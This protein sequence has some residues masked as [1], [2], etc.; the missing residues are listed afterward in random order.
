MKAKN[1]MAAEINCEFCNETSLQTTL[2]WSCANSSSSSSLATGLSQNRLQIINYLSQLLLWLIPCLPLR[3]SHCVHTLQTISYF[4][5]HTDTSPPPCQNWNLWPASFLL[6][7]SKAMESSPFWYLSH[8]VLPCLQNCFKDSPRA[9]NNST[10]DFKFCLL[11]FLISPSP[12]S[13]SHPR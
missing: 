11:S 3:P 2:T 9:T 7:C 13:F 12:T 1:N 4:C 10:T 8:L 5:R 6:L